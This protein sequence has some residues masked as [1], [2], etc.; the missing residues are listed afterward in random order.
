MTSNYALHTIFQH[1]SFPLENTVNHVPRAVL[2][3]FN[4]QKNKNC[5]KLAGGIT[6]KACEFHFI[7]VL[8]II[9]FK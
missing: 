6:A 8:I 3:I 9:I 5:Y 1:R 4:A 7:D 2:L